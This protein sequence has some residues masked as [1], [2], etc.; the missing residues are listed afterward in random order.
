MIEA[1][2]HRSRFKPFISNSEFRVGF[3]N[4]G[5]FQYVLARIHIGR[6]RFVNA[7]F[8]FKELFVHGHIGH[9]TPICKTGVVKQDLS[10]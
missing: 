3:P 10:F 9:F 5:N 8:P 2:N 6:G 1:L 7:Y 4:A